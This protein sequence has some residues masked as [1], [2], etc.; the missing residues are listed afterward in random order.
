MHC[1]SCTARVNV[2]VWARLRAWCRHRASLWNR[3]LQL[4]EP[5]PYVHIDTGSAGYAMHAPAAYFFPW[6]AASRGFFCHEIL[7]TGAP[8]ISSQYLFAAHAPLRSEYLISC[9]NA[10]VQRAWEGMRLHDSLLVL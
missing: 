1:I 10:C 3:R 8:E 2:H 7:G 6:W 5:C 9:A 4:L